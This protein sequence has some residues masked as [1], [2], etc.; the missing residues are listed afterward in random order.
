MTVSGLPTSVDFSHKNRGFGSDF[1]A[2]QRT[3]KR[4]AKEAD[5]VRCKNL[6]S[7]STQAVSQE[8]SEI[9]TQGQAPEQSI[10]TLAMSTWSSASTTI[11]DR[12]KLLSVWDRFDRLAS[13]QGDSFANRV[14][15]TTQS[16]SRESLQQELDIYVSDPVISRSSCPLQWWN[17]NQ[18]RFPCVS[19]VAREY[20]MIPATS[21]PSERLFSKAGDIIS[22]KCSSIK[23]SRADQTIFLMENM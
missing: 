8:T 13:N 22:K 19:A 14:S 20:L 21:V 15:Q 5:E 18:Q 17:I 7:S 23:P 3:S 11:T 16:P 6:Q 12:P 1:A 10:A 9:S 4:Q 2:M